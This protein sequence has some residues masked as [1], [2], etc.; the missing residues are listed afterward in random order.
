MLHH[1]L[2]AQHRA[3]PARC[4]PTPVP[5]ARPAWGRSERRLL[6]VTSGQWSI[7]ELKDHMTTARAA[8]HGNGAPPGHFLLRPS[9]SRQSPCFPRPRTPGPS[10]S[11]QSLPHL[12]LVTS[13]QSQ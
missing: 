2:D 3:S 9:P 11:A 13:L 5:E 8:L 1:P 6:T 10:L 12:L 7:S 4:R